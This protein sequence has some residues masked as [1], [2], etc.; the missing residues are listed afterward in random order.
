MRQRISHILIADDDPSTHQ[1][2]AALQARQYAVATASTLEDGYARLAERPV[3]LVVAGKRVGPLSGLQF[4]ITC[5]ARRPELTGILL[6]TYGDAVPEM[7]AWRH[8]IAALVAPP[9]PEIFLMTVAE[10]LATIRRRQQWPR[11]QLTTDMP[12][13]VAGAPGRL[14][15]VSYGGLRLEVASDR[16]ELGPQLQVDIPPANLRVTGELVWSARHPKGATCVCGVSI[17]GNHHPAPLWRE[18][19]D[20]LN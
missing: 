8:G 19:V 2:A 9:D 13:E 15:D 7:D 20:E 5:R 10:K 14:L 1:H 3:D 4:I 17:L 16:Y 11:K 18:F 6:S 12:V